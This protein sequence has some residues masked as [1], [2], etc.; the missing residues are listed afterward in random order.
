MKC[1]FSGKEIPVG[2]GIKFFKRDG[3]AVYFLNRKAEKSYLMRKS[4]TK[5]KWTGKATKHKA[6]QEK[7]SEVKAQP[8]PQVQVKQ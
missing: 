2:T 8:I 6:T 5:M 3:T 7:K 4:P 1:A